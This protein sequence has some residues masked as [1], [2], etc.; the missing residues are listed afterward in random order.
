VCFDFDCVLSPKEII[1]ELAKLAKVEVEVTEITRLAMNGAL[2]YRTSL[3]RRVHLLKGLNKEHL[4]SLGKKLPVTPGVKQVVDFLLEKEILP[5]IISGGF[6]EV[7][8]ETN[9]Q[10]GIPLIVANSLEIKDGKLTG[11]VSGPCLTAEAKGEVLAYLVERFNIPMGKTSAVC[12][13][14]NDINLL[15][16]VAFPIG[17]RPKNKIK[18]YIKYY[19]TNDM[20]EILGYLLV[21]GF[22]EY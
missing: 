22:F 2:N 11:N 15:R 18:E 20:R 19:S 10:I 4:Y 21:E 9:K 6:I 13:G 8:S 16:K 7:I 3:D 12:D 5:V 1:N 14:A 17:F